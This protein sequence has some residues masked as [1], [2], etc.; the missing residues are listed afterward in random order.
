MI[1]SADTHLAAL[2]ALAAWVH[3]H[4]SVENKLH[5]VRDVAYRE[6][7]SRVRTGH[8]T[9]DHGHPAQHRDQPAPTRR[10]HQHHRRLT[11]PPPTT[12]QDHHPPEQHNHDSAVTLVSEAGRREVAG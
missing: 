9:P 10:R 4:W 1:T 12:R 3:G 7:A 11:P 6:D 5:Y 8:A 2:A